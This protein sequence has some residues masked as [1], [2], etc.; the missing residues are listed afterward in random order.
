MV[1]QGRCT[2]KEDIR[3]IDKLC[4]QLR[5]TRTQRRLLHDEITRQQFTRE[6]IRQIAQDLLR[7]TSPTR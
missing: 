6:E 4:K 1:L 7:R 3:H 5:L 2:R